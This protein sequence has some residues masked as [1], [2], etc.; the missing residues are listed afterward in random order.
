VPS[1]YALSEAAILD[2]EVRERLHERAWEIMGPLSS[3]ARREAAERYAEL[4]SELQIQLG[5]E[6]GQQGI[7][8]RHTYLR[9]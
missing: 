7:A 2:P 5:D 1:V 6:D 8:T 4:D 9:Y 3:E